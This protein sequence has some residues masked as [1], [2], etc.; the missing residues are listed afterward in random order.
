[1]KASILAAAL[2]GLTA[3]S[4]T[5][6]SVLT[7][8]GSLARSC[9]EA[10]EARMA[11]AQNLRTC[12]RALMEEALDTHDRVATFVNRGILRL[13]TGDF[14]AADK[15]F[16]R[17]IAI[18]PREPESWLNK[19]VSTIRQGNS[20]AAVPMIARAIELNTRRPAL[21]FYTRGIAHENR[22]DVKAAYADLVRARELEPEWDLPAKEL[23]RYQVRH[24]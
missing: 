20:A 16:D 6:A 8:G 15:D 9:F 21:A 23:A 12:D 10:A 4:A 2:V 13:A 19:G 5:N 3:S 7:I 14:R 22:G 17:A 11:T 24:R 18:D 1:M